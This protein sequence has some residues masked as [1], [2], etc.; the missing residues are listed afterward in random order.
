[1]CGP[2][3][4]QKLLDLLKIN[5]LVVVAA[6]PRGGILNVFRT[7]ERTPLRLCFHA[8]HPKSKERFPHLSSPGLGSLGPQGGLLGGLQKFHVGPPP[9]ALIEPVFAWTG[10][11]SLG[12]VMVWEDI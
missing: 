11:A 7:P 4:L 10:Y 9:Q 6:F 5:L 2:Q 8:I 1:M 12:S 3:R